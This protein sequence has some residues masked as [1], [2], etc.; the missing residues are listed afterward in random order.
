MNPTFQLKEAWQ[1]NLRL[2]PRPRFTI[3]TK[4]ILECFK[5]ARLL[6][7]TPKLFSMLEVE[8]IISAKKSSTRRLEVKGDHVK[9][10]KLFTELENMDK[11]KSD[12]VYLSSK[13][14]II[15][16]SGLSSALA[17]ILQFFLL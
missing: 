15:V 16:V 13:G 1:S 7:K 2:I 14:Q 3:V 4:S 17:I 10:G 8:F 11:S 5:L 6:R 9:K 12:A